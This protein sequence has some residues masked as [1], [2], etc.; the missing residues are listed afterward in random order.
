METRP[1]LSAYRSHTDQQNQNTATESCCKRQYRDLQFEVI[2]QRWYI[3]YWNNREIYAYFD[4]AITNDIERNSYPSFFFSLDRVRKSRE[5][6][7]E[8]RTEDADKF[9]KYCTTVAW[10]SSTKEIL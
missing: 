1:W 8:S 10:L 7:T 9:V 5:N 6:I 3:Y 4:S 2:E